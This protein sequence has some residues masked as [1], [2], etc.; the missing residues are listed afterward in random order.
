[1]FVLPRSSWYVR[2]RGAE[3]LRRLDVRSTV[4]QSRLD[5]VSVK[6]TQKYII[7][8]RE[9]I[10]KDLK[11]FGQSFKNYVLKILSWKKLLEYS[12]LSLKYKEFLDLI[13][14]DPGLLYRYIYSTFNN[15]FKTQF[16]SILHIVYN[17]FKTCIQRKDMKKK[18]TH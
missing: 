14:L 9:L 11:I 4:S 17:G 16:I 10:L 7:F 5:H 15:R 8:E 1:M 12:Y 18:E 2:P 13:K 3:C 6:C